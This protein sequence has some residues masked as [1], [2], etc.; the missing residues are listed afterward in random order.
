MPEH[1]QKKKP[2]LKRILIG[3]LVVVVILAGVYWYYATEKFADT[4][5]KKADYTLNALD[6]IREFQQDIAAANKKYTDKIIELNGKVSA[7]EAADTTVNIKM[8]EPAT[9]SYVIFAFQQQHL[10]EAKSVK[11]GDSISVKGSF[12][13][14]IYSEILEA[15]AISFKRST[16][17]NKYPN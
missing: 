7:I 15:T 17:N 16:L 14:G 1:V 8:V 2:W 9:A 3:I 5:S 13:G 11:E 10:S 6:F 12:G 4:K